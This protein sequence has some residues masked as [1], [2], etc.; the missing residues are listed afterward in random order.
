[1]KKYSFTKGLGKALVA[2]VVFGLPILIEVLPSDV[3]NLSVST[4]LAM[5]LNYL[6]TKQIITLP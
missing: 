3:L 4:I 2:L 1:M 5:I 6:K